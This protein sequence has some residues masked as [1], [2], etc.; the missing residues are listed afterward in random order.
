MPDPPVFVLMCLHR[1][2]LILTSV[3]VSVYLGAIHLAIIL[4][5]LAASPLSE[6]IL[7][8]PII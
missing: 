2:F 1:L 5:L 7:T 6:I 4:F 3:T 8:A